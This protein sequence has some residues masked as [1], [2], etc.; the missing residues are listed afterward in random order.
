MVRK[1]I[2]AFKKIKKGEKFTKNNL[3]I[4]RPSDGISPMK[5]FQIIGR[6]AKKNYKIDEIIK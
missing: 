3:F 4:K 1:S 6:K 5:Y 2:V